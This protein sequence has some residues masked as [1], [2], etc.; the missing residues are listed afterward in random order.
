MQDSEQELKGN[1]LFTCFSF[2]VPF[3]DNQPKSSEGSSESD[4]EE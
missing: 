1:A 4:A 2:H 3:D